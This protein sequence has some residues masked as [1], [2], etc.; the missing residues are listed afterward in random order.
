MGL[1]NSKFPQFGSHCN[2]DRSVDAHV[3]HENIGVGLPRSNQ[4]T[5]MIYLGIEIMD[6][7][8]LGR[9]RA[10][11]ALDGADR[12]HR[13]LFGGNEENRVLTAVLRFA[14]Y[15]YRPPKHHFANLRA[16]ILERP[17]TNRVQSKVRPWAYGT[18]PFG[19]GRRRVSL[20]RKVGAHSIGNS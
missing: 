11:F 1:A 5:H 4:L 9:V 14:E 12:G 13:R 8:R 18:F 15:L 19:N 20:T 10:M 7:Q 17:P 16:E 3:G 6:S 2:R